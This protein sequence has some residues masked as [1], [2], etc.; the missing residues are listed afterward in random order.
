MIMRKIQIKGIKESVARKTVFW[1]AIL[2]ALTAYEF[3]T[4]YPEVYPL[5]QNRLFTLEKNG[6]YITNWCCTILSAFFCARQMKKFQ[7]TR[8]ISYLVM[9]YLNLIY[10]IPG[11]L[12]C[13]IY[14]TDE[15]YNL[16]Y[17]LFWIF[18]NLLHL[19]M[20]YIYNPAGKMIRSNKYIRLNYSEGYKTKFNYFAIAFILFVLGISLVLSDL[21]ISIASLLNQNAVL[22]IRAAAAENNIHW[23]AWNPIL[24][25]SMI[26][27]VWY[28]LAQKRKKIWIMV[29][30]VVTTCAMYT[31]SAN[32]MFLFLLL[33]A[34]VITV[35]KDDDLLFVKCWVIVLGLIFLEH[36]LTSD[37][38]RVLNVYRRLSLTPNSESRF[39]I[40]FFSNNEL[41]WA[42][43]LLERWLIIFGI[44]SP[45]STRIP[46]MIGQ[47]YLGG[48]N[49]N[50]G[51][52][53]YCFGNYGIFGIFFGP[54]LYMISFLL[55]DKVTD[56]LRHKKTLHCT[57]IV[58]AI[59]VTNDYGWAE[60]LILPS[61]LLIYYILLFLMPPVQDD[62]GQ[63]EE[64]YWLFRI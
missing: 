37:S 57:A 14:K 56:K 43:Q 22:E 8:I 53:G 13:A 21:R 34:V 3:Y 48:S 23:L 32:R 64:E 24:A 52:L 15:T 20:M 1:Y 9:F 45:Y 41:D 33:F 12:M 30:I 61:F 10:Y 47:Y 31:V 28:T 16:Y 11:F 54:L 38:Y 4:I 2:I 29:L 17:I 44:K 19:I 58:Y 27:P 62:D 42:R 26:L 40:D 7:R 60:Y 5:Y 18:L 35:F 63:Q 59:M 25:A 55:L 46:A 39:Y 6:F 36:Y 49:C 50:T 51:L